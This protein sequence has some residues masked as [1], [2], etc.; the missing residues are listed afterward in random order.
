MLKLIYLRN[1]LDKMSGDGKEVL[2]NQSAMQ[3][4]NLKQSL[5]EWK[6]VITTCDGL[7]NTPDPVKT[8]AAYAGIY[9]T[10]YVIFLVTN[11]SY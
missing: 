1:N 8:A 4:Q 5:N 9:T 3:V 7:I 2:A 6:Y 11:V 10:V